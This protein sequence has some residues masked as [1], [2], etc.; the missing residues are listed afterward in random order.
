MLMKYLIILLEHRIVPQ[1]GDYHPS[2]LSMKSEYKSASLWFVAP[3][4]F[5][6]YSDKL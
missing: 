6:K 3:Q 5:H 1:L 4:P 2:V